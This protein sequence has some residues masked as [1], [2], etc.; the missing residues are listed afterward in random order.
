MRNKRRSTGLLIV[1]ILMWAAAC[2]DA[3]NDPLD[4][5]EETRLTLDVAAYVADQTID[6]IAVMTFETQGLFGGPIAGPPGGGMHGFGFD[7]SLSVTRTV[8]F[9]DADGEPMDWYHAEDTDSIH[10]YFLLEGERSRTTD[11]G[12][13]TMEVRRERN[14]GVSGLA[15][16]ETERTWNGTGASSKERA[17]VSDEW[18]DRSYEMSST[19]IVTNVVIRLPHAEN[20]W[21]VSGTIERTVHVEWVKDGE[22][23][24]RDC[25]VLITFN[26]TQFVTIVING[27]E[28]LFDLATKKIVEDQQG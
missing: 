12:S 23:R 24:T 17:V 19:S 20:P 10:I 6:D 13:M 14:M 4:A 1:P 8:E 5:A 22:T 15:G 28:F 7:G 16:I 11:R 9:F 25:T 18:G 21:P 26:D 2:S 27:E 3:P